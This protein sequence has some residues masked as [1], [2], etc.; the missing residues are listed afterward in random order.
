[1]MNS[2]LNCYK[3]WHLVLIT[4]F[5]H[6]FIVFYD[7]LNIKGYFPRYQKSE[8][9]FCNHIKYSENKRITLKFTEKVI[10]ST[11]F[12]INFYIWTNMYSVESTMK[13][14]KLE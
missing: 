5:L 9:G 2:N 1:M 6:E 4:Q 11:L 10:P 14:K 12:L 3:T 13:M 8:K 7:S